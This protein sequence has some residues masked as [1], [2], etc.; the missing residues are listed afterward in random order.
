MLNS[1]TLIITS[2]ILLQKNNMKNQYKYYNFLLKIYSTYTYQM[3]SHLNDY[4]CFKFFLMKD[5]YKFYFKKL[6]FY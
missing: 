5:Y 4:L 1:Q 2:T 3:Y 6:L